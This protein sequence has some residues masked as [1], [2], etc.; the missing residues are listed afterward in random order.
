MPDFVTPVISPLHTD[1]TPPIGNSE[2]DDLRGRAHVKISNK[3]SEPIPISGT[4]TSV[5]D[6]LTTSG[7]QATVAVT[8]T[9]Q[10]LRVGVSNLSNRKMIFVQPINGKIRV[11]FI[12]VTSSL[13]FLLAK[14]QFFALPVAD[15]LDF[16]IVAT[17]GSVNVTIGEGA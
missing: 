16:Y 12:G 7:L 6:L 10:I 13:G 9:P 11:G 5:A 2:G 14:D 3:S 1:R 8:T 17:S 15:S 4:I